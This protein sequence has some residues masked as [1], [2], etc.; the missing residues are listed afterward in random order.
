MDFKRR[1]AFLWRWAWLIILGTAVAGSVAF[2]AS[3]NSVP[4]YQ[5]STRLLINA[6]PKSDFENAQSA[7]TYAEILETESIRQEIIA[8][9]E[10]PIS[11]AQ[12]AE[13]VAVSVPEGTQIIRIN[14]SDVSSDRAALIA[15]ALSQT[16][17]DQSQSWASQ[18]Y[19]EPIANW[20]NRLE[21]IDAEIQ[22]LN[23][24]INALD[25]AED[26]QATFSRLETQ[27]E[28]AQT[29]YGDAFNQ[30]N[31]SHTAQAQ[32][33]DVIIQIEAAQPNAVPILP[34]TAV[35]TIIAALVGGL[36]AAGIAALASRSSPTNE[37]EPA[38]S[39]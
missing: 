28:N 4:V 7:R 38:Q 18:R 2:F 20:Q 13:M 9:L 15:N 34:R 17:I 8:Q 19:A 32:E 3:Q 37:N 22:A 31:E 39:S 29:R 16:L 25:K 24:Q 35:N 27:L 36:T 1:A 23:A 33:S 30:F 12:L 5:A 10:L 26:A 21:E 11:S 6:A 14:V